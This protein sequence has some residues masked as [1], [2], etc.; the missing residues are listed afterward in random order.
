VKLLPWLLTALLVALLL[1]SIDT[2]VLG[3]ALRAS[4]WRWIVA[5]TLVSLFAIT[6]CRTQRFSA[7]VRGL[8]HPDGRRARFTELVSILSASRALNLVLPARAGETLRAMQMH[9]RFGYPVESIVAAVAM[10]T[11]LETIALGAPAFLLVSLGLARSD[12][13][14]FLYPAILAGSACLMLAVYLHW[15]RAPRERDS[16]AR[17]GRIARALRRFRISAELIN[18][19]RVSLKG[20]AWTLL[21]DAFDLSMI[22][23]S[24]TATGISLDVTAW[25]LILVAINVAIVVPTPGN[26]G[27]LE[28]GAVLV[29]GAY[30][31]D[32]SHALAFSLLYH[33]AHLIPVVLL[34]GVSLPLEF[35]LSAR[36]ASEA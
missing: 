4:D 24:L 34:G 31:V 32:Q 29:L 8:P 16:L 13:A 3:E 23:L 33:A 19:P 35:R 2:Q 15:R 25:F 18:H 36:S 12:L 1:R 5:A 20:L 30:G 27:T 22:G 6:F 21:S 26:L 14:K 7:L 10:E 28:A 9:R 11:V 17:G